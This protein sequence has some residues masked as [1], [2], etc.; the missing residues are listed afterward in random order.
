MVGNESR[1]VSGSR[2]VEVELPDVGGR[3]RPDLE[4]VLTAH[5]G[6]SRPK[7][8]QELGQVFQEAP[9]Q[10]PLLGPLPQHQKVEVV[11]VLQELLRQVGL[12]RGQRRREISQG[13]A[14]PLQ[15]AALDLVGERVAA[16]LL[17]PGLPGVLEARLRL[18][19]LLQQDDIV[20]PRQFCH[21]LWQILEVRLGEGAH[22]PEVAGGE[23]LDA[24]EG[25]LEVRGEPLDDACAPALG[26]LL[27][28]DAAS[29]LPVEAGKFL[30]DGQCG[31]HLRGTDAVLQSGDEAVAPLVRE[32]FRLAAFNRNSLKEILT[33]LTDK[34]LI[35]QRGTP[36]HPSGLWRILTD[37]FY[38][39]RFMHDGETLAGAHMPIIGDALFAQVQRC[40]ASRRRST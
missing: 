39:A 25:G 7:L 13:A 38:I 36:L 27:G 34:G 8:Q 29:D 20:R 4:V 9:F 19:E 6:E 33:I 1:S 2:E 32:A 37:P 31:P 23:A 12:R 35:S 10:I 26:G 15:E 22:P 28:G 17:L 24:G 3:E 30:V 21:R 14:L 16:P 11:G 18:L 40:L 5:E